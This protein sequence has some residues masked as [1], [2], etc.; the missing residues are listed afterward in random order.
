MPK[1]SSSRT[2]WRA[3]STESRYVIATCAPSSASAK[4][5]PR[6]MRFAAPVTS[7]TLSCNFFIPKLY[8]LADGTRVFAEFRDRIEGAAPA[9]AATQKGDEHGAKKS[10]D[11]HGG[12]DGKGEEVGGR[13]SVVAVE[14]AVEK[15]KHKEEQRSRNAEPER[16][17]ERDEG[18]EAE[19]NEHSAGDER[20][21]GTEA[22]D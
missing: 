5:M 20:G 14:E 17:C 13:N 19:R 22:E 12:C 9:D 18:S 1:S 7:A 15:E 11:E 2:V 16:T 10:V 6:P 8:L 4:A 21:Q 3:S